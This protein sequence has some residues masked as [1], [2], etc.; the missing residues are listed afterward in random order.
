M[1]SSKTDSLQVPR[2]NSEEQNDLKTTKWEGK[3]KTYCAGRDSCITQVGP[4]PRF[5]SKKAEIEICG[6]CANEEKHILGGRRLDFLCET[7]L[8]T[9]RVKENREILPTFFFF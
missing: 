5:P 9:V 1:D 8:K 3:V 2:D 6:S 4:M 7:A